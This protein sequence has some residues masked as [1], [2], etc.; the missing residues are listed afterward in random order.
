MGVAI[1][2]RGPA[3][4][5]FSFGFPWISL[6]LISSA[7]PSFKIGLLVNYMWY[8]KENGLAAMLTAKRSAGVIP[9]VN[10]RECSR[11]CSHLA[12]VNEK[13][14]LFFD[15]LSFFFDLF[16]HFFDLIHFRICFC[17]V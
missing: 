8:M 6:G 1:L 11:D 4:N 5:H 3:Y 17:L 15:V 9:E 10:L 13:A 12:T 2:Q 16:R 7:T 14:K